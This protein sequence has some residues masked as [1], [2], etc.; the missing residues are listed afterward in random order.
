M[1]Q[2]N[3]RTATHTTPHHSKPCSPTRHWIPDDDA[4]SSRANPLRRPS[5]PKLAMRRNG[6]TTRK[7][8]FS[9]FSPLSL[10]LS[11]SLSLPPSLSQRLSFLSFSLSRSLSLSLLRKLALE[12]LRQKILQQSNPSKN[13]NTPQVLN[14][15]RVAR[16]RRVPPNASWD[17]NFVL[18]SA[19]L[20]ASFLNL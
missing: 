11:F 20:H 15:T 8:R 1:P 9:L 18:C 7:L 2:P 13:V 6:S 14:G 5:Q 4:A 12:A 10:S 3:P 16:F 19:T 17:V